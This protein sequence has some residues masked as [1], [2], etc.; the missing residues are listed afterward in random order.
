MKWWRREGYPVHKSTSNAMRYCVDSAPRLGSPLSHRTAAI[1]RTPVALSTHWESGG[2]TAIYAISNVEAPR[3]TGRPGRHRARQGGHRVGAAQG[4]PGG[5]DEVCR[6]AVKIVEGSAAYPDGSWSGGL[7]D[8]KP[9]STQTPE[10]LTRLIERKGLTRIS[11]SSSSSS[12]SYSP[13]STTA[14][15]VAAE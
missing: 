1:S 11:S 12:S 6:A 9:L 14:A 4:L 13:L 2:R 8:R 7:Q 5:Q 15:T 10:A 3:P